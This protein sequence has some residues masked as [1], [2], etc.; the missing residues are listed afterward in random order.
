MAEVGLGQT[1][2]R[3]GLLVECDVPMKQFIIHLA[4]QY[5]QEVKIA[6]KLEEDDTHIFLHDMES[7]NFAQEKMKEEQKKLTWEEKADS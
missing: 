1:I 6:H 3:R 5:P 7:F 2:I 4:S